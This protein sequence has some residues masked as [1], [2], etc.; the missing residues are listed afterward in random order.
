MAARFVANNPSAVEGLVLW[1]SHPADDNDLSKRGLEAVSIY[2]TLDSLSINRTVDNTRHLL[3]P[4]SRW[5]PIEGGT[6]AQFGWY[7]SQKGENIATI[8]Q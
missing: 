4:Q 1:S 6:H 5:V 8:S 7:G 3:P 2:E